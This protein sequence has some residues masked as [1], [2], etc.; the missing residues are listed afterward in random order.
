MATEEEIYGSDK[1]GQVAY[2]GASENYRAGQRGLL[3][4]DHDTLAARELLNLQMRSAHAIRNNGTAKA[5]QLKRIVALGA[6]TVNWKGKDKLEHPLMQELWDEFIKNPNLDG[7]GDF[8]GT[9]ALWN[10]SIFQAGAAITNM[11]F[12]KSDNSNR[13]PL[14]LQAIP[15]EMLDVLYNGE[16]ERDNIHHGIKFKDSKPTLYHFRKGI[17]NEQWLGIANR[18]NHT[19]IPAKNIVHIFDRTSP[20]QW[21]GVPEL[22]SVLMSLYELDDLIDATVAKQKAAQAVA[23]VI[24]NTNPLNMN[25][26]GVVR[27]VDDP[28]KT[29]DQTITNSAAANTQYMQ[30]GEKIHFSQ[31][32]DIGANLPVLIKMIQ[33]TIAS[34]Q[35]LPYHSLTGDTSGVDF[36]SL[37]AIAMDLRSALTFIHHV[38]TIPLGLAPVTKRFKEYAALHHD[39][40]D[41][42]PTFQLPKWLSVDDLKDGQADLL[43]LSIG[44]TTFQR[45]LEENHLTLAEIEES[46]AMLD[47]VGLG[48]L[49]EKKTESGKQTGNVEPNANSTTK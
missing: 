48:H 28:A 1:L 40:K 41:A 14:K 24:E 30:K 4:G 8:K 44:G 32:T 22:S 31:G 2:E 3:E 12:K 16:Q 20:S 7:H 43:K 27:Q 26:V 9:Q 19:K 6:I 42:E 33:Q 5:A 49:M 35:S 39:V 36:S 11:L 13:V 10:N 18:A 45:V 47:K 21:L 25:S 46:K 23:W 17:Y 38:R 34:A 37:R 15:T 29:E